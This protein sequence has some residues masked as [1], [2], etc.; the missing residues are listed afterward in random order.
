MAIAEIGNTKFPKWYFSGLFIIGGIF[1]ISFLVNTFSEK[2]PRADMLLQ[3][4]NSMVSE[5]DMKKD[6]ISYKIKSILDVAVE[7]GIDPE[8]FKYFTKINGE[9]VLM[10][11]QVPDLKKVEKS[12]RKD[13][14]DIINTIADQQQDLQNKSRFIAVKGKVTTMLVKTP[15]AEENSTVAS[16]S[17]LYDFYGTKN[18]K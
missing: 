13:L 11:L 2:D 14:I 18:K 6:S 10:L 17:S 16:E 3:D 7:D 15:T 5:P 12:S 9:K 1:L 4:M 8:K